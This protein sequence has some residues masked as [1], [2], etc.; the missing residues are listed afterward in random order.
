MA[1][2]GNSSPKLPYFSLQTETTAPIFGAASTFGAGTGFGGFT[3][4][5]VEN[6]GDAVETK[7]DEEEEATPEEE[8]AAEFQPVV[9]LDE[10]AVSTGEEEEAALF[11]AKC[12]LYRFDNDSGEWK[13]RGI[14]QAKLLQHKENKR[15]R[16]LMRQEKTL[17]IRSNHIVMPGTKVQEHTGSEKA[18]V[19]TCVD[20]AD[21]V[22]RTELFCVRFASAERAGEFRDAYTDACEKNKVTLGLDGE[23]EEEERGEEEENEEKKAA[24]ELAEKVEG[25]K[26]EEEEKENEDK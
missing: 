12:K 18:M 11:D 25:V 1:S 26:V 14:G 7:D 3:G 20:Y 6:N 4:L 10:V 22:Q 2:S 5:K 9:Q 23:E 15:I 17:K 19:W 8:C 21:E 16:F 24:D 13:E